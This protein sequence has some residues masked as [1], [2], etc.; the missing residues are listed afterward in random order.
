MKLSSTYA[1][2][3]LATTLATTYARLSAKNNIWDRKLQDEDFP[4]ACHRVYRPVCG[5][6]GE[7]YS[8][9]CMA[10]ASGATV[11]YQG[12]CMEDDPIMCSAIYQ[13]VCGANG[14]TYSNDCKANV[15]G[16]TVVSKGRCPE[17]P[18]DD[19][20]MCRSNYRPVCGANGKTYSNDCKAKVAGT[21]AKS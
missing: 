2:L 16:T 14:K 13:P 17:V 4:V 10:K 12:E 3:A 15:A 20:I 7:T 21:T 11:A 18:T 1:L 8:N 6:D 19:P 9:G 5:T